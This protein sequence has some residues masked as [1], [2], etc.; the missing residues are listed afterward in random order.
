MLGA[1]QRHKHAWRKGDYLVVTWADITM[2]FA[3]LY[4]GDR[5]G[6]VQRLKSYRARAIPATEWTVGREN[7]L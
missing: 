1:Q 6:M 2:I 3:R 7:A 4:N 5:N